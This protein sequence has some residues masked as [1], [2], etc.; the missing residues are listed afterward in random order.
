ME[1]VGDQRIMAIVHEAEENMALQQRLNEITENARMLSTAESQQIALMDREA[2]AAVVE[3][4]E[5]ASDIV[6]NMRRD[7]N[8]ARIEFGRQN[9]MLKHFESLDASRQLMCQ[10]L[11]GQ[12]DKL[13]MRMNIMAHE[14]RSAMQLEKI[15]YETEMR[16][17]E[18][19]DA[20][21]IT[22]LNNRLVSVESQLE[23]AYEVMHDANNP[24][25][26]SEAVRR[27]NVGQYDLAT[28]NASKEQR[29][30]GRQG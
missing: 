6:S 7:F 12:N 28:S 16:I 9:M 30:R 24:Q 15:E 23:R 13:E 29:R 2:N 1:N 20:E 8:E 22:E 21:E 26:L 3:A 27:A 11:H 5:Q 19:A 18:Q 4:R 14:H 17:D 25:A 10:E